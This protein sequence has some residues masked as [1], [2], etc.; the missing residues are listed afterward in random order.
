MTGRRVW[1]TLALLAAAC[2]GGAVAAAD[3][4][5]PRVRVA[6]APEV[7]AR[8]GLGAQLA[9]LVWIETVAAG[10]AADLSVLA[11]SEG[12][13]LRA[14][15]GRTLALAPSGEALAGQ[16]AAWAHRLLVAGLDNPASTLALDFVLERE[17]GPGALGTVEPGAALR[18][19]AR[20]R[21]AR[22]VHPL[23]FA[24]SADGGV[25]LVYPWRGSAR[26]LA[27]GAAVEQ[28]VEVDAPEGVERATD[29]LTLLVTSA[30]VEAAAFLDPARLA[31]ALAEL[32]DVEWRTARAEIHV[33]RYL[34]E[35]PAGE[36][37]GDAPPEARPEARRAPRTA[38]F[39]LRFAGEVELGA[40]Q[41]RL[42]RL[43]TLCG[44]TGKACQVRRLP[45]DGAVFELERRGMRLGEARGQTLAQAFEQAYAIRAQVGAWRVEPGFA[46]GA[47]TAPPG[48]S[49]PRWRAAYG[50]AAGRAEADYRRLF[51]G[52]ELDAVAYL[53]AEL[54]YHRARSEEVARAF[55][56]LAAAGSDPSADRLAGARAAWLREG[57]SPSLRRALGG[58]AD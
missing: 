34:L 58:A 17:E 54:L 33:R 53:E 13:A 36:A 2:S 40:V 55:A 29:R 23:L 47:E 30:P 52:A 48:G 12:V 39:G 21:S 8:T 27:P 14:A 22:A 31:D 1:I 51:G 10:A 57:L 5:G 50:A 24:I 28:V 9:P 41:S 7:E 44:S 11:T 42:A 19:E 6:V 4:A 37:P 49:V 20:N 15:D 3:D 32:S 45:G 16:V 43:R 26:A 25:S 56:A 18:W 46:L 35:P 38:T